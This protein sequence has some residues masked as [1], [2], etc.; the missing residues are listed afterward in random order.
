MN[1]QPETQKVNARLALNEITTGR[2]NLRE[3]ICYLAQAA[4]FCYSKE[5]KEA[6]RDFLAN[7]IRH[8]Q[9]LHKYFG[10]KD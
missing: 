7:E 8:L 10:L 9:G 1:I 6:M 5:N 2:K 4:N 3:A